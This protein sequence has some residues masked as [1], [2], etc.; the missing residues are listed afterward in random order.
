M[1]I[2]I[3]ASN[4]HTGGGKII[5]NDII[6]ITHYF[7]D[8]YFNF[9]IDQ[10]FFLQK[11]VGENISFKRIKKYHRFLVWFLIE[12]HLKKDDIVIYFTNTPPIFKHKCKTI[13][14]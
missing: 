3:N 7:K 13:Y 12:K 10:R 11:I 6:I 14:V 1:N 5:L 8:I 2:Y 4:I 9:Y